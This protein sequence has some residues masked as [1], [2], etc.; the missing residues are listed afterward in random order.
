MIDAHRHF[1]RY[2][3]SMHG[4]IDDSM[5]MLKHDFLPGDRGPL[6]AAGEDEGCIAVQALHS[7]AETSW[8]LS[9]S[10]QHANLLGVVGWVD[11]C[12]IDA[13]QRL[14]DLCNHPHFVGV[15]HLLQ[16]EPDAQFMARAD[17]R[18]GLSE[19]EP[20]DL[21]FDILVRE[22]QRDS[23]IEL[24]RAFPN[25]R[26]V[27]DHMAKP[28]LRAGVLEPWRRQLRD[29]AR[30]ENLFCKLSALATEA[31]LKAW[32]PAELAPYVEVALECFGPAR[33][34]FGSDYPVCLLAGDTARVID[35]HLNPLRQLSPAEFRA[36]THTNALR[37]YGLSP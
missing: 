27:L 7:A 28:D 6:E 20:R 19:L 10:M 8:L 37:A 14:D 3:P 26:F 15:R 12:A 35:A 21:C 34:I 31:D 2:S 13:A 1:W 18:R 24:V 11:L 9:S 22:P 5:P 29:L 16:D 30:S 23:A 32:K 33:L 4:W 17:F 25:Q 36:V